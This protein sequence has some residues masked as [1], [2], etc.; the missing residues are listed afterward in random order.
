[1]PVEPAAEERHAAEFEPRGS[2]AVEAPPQKLRHPALLERPV[3]ALAHSGGRLSRSFV[4]SWHRIRCRRVIVPRGSQ[5]HTMLA[6][7]HGWA[8]AARTR[9]SDGGIP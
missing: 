6:A 2:Q 4:V 5:H 7:S 3:Q 1:P 8:N 9:G